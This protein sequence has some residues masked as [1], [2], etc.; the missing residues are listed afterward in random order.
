MKNLCQTFLTL[1]ILFS[2]SIKIHAQ[3]EF[4]F[5]LS[6][7]VEYTNATDDQKLRIL[8]AYD[9]SL[10]H[11]K[12]NIFLSIPE[13]LTFSIGIG[14]ENI[15][16]AQG[17]GAGQLGAPLI[18]ALGT[19]IAKRF[20]EELTLA[21]L[22]SFREKLRAE[23][24]LGALFPNSKN[25]LLNGDPFNHKI[26]L[27]SFRGAMD[28]D[29]IVLPDNIPS[30]LNE[31]KKID[32]LTDG[33]KLAISSMI[34]AYE[35]S[36]SFVRNPEESYLSTL[37]LI[38]GFS[39]VDFNNLN[40]TASL[41][42]AHLIIKE[43][44]NA[45]YN[46]WA[47]KKALENLANI[48]TAKIFIGFVI[49]KYRDDLSLIKMSNGNSLTDLFYHPGKIN[50]EDFTRFTIEVIYKVQDILENVNSLKI[51]KRTM[52]LEYS[53]YIPLIDRSMALL[54]YVLGDDLSQLF[55]YPEA[56]EL[57]KYLNYSMLS[58][59]FASD[60]E[61]A[62]SEKN[63]SKIMVSTIAFIKNIIP[64][65]TLSS[66]TVFKEFVKYGNFAISLV[67][68]ETSEDMVA[69]IEGA[70]L[71]TQS[72]RL[73]RNS[74]FSV[75]INSY[76]GMFYARE[77]LINEEALNK[78][79]GVTG[80]TAPIGVGLNWGIGKSKKPTKFNK[81]ASKTVIESG[82]VT[83]TKYFKGHSISFFASILDVGAITTFRLTD[84]QTPVTDVQ[85]QNIF[86]P[87]AYF[88][89]GIGNT[90]LAL[91]VGGQYGPELRTVTAVDGV[92]TSTINSS[93]WRFG[94]SLVVDIPFF[95]LYAKTEKV[96]IK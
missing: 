57:S 79:S 45:R 82:E 83:E 27:T 13:N 87:G 91:M 95:H 65:E 64:Q 67:G 96:E 18:D 52:R 14:A 73:K 93:A 22:E 36:L 62:I 71:P 92:A 28:E 40:T 6:D 76:A 84:D 55:K 61:N 56:S 8:Y 34:A 30:L 47:N 11:L 25:V 9:S 86:A 2:C 72:Y 74:Y 69:A 43:I 85:W 51:K 21:F 41:K 16:V 60:L 54:S 33:Q 49:E 78:T 68:A 7:A 23:S 26:W 31:L 39:E 59:S 29:L 58:V 24:Y 37:K 70:A 94:I 48:E 66:S 17:V 75:S 81:Y 4:R 88:V 89:W 32:S 50:V 35:P 19:V 63:Y 42:L 80:F 77:F 1:F 10:T 3:K 90:P 53:D 44:G 38:D 12:K 20:K 15:I 5:P 46:D